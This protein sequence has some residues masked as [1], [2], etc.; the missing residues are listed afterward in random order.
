[1]ILYSFLEGNHDVISS[2][3]L[4]IRKTNMKMS[5]ILR[6]F[7]TVLVFFALGFGFCR[8]A[9]AED[10]DFITIGVG[11]YDWDLKNEEGEE[12]RLEYRSSSKFWGFKPLVSLAGTTTGQGFLGAGLLLDVFIGRRFVFTPSIVPNLY[13]GG[14]SKLDLGYFIE[15]RSQLE[16]SYRFDDRSRLGLAVSHYSNAGMGDDNVGTE[17]A[18][19]YFS[20]PYYKLFGK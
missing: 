7:K 10:P 1:M 13:F 6:I 17:S 18:I 20:V 15:I 4:N 3:K 14:N 5:S 16:A 12:L 2:S 8:P 19:V 9:L 11:A